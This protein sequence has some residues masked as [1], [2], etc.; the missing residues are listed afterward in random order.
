MSANSV[1]QIL[2]K[3]LDSNILVFAERIIR[4]KTCKKPPKGVT[5]KAAI[6]SPLKGKFSCLENR[7]QGPLHRNNVTPSLG[8]KK[9]IFFS[10]APD[11]ILAAMTLR[12]RMI[13][14]ADYLPKVICNCYAGP[15]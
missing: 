14:L 12:Y 7:S 2:I 8:S 9:I 1:Q 5:N 6:T 3:P 15:I 11:I 13:L 10:T 4:H